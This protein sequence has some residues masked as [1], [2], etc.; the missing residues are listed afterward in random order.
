MQ[1]NNRRI[2]FPFH[3]RCTLICKQQ[4]TKPSIFCL[5]IKGLTQLHIPDVTQ[6]DPWKLTRLMK[7]FLTHT[8]C[9][10]IRDLAEPTD[11]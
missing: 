9:S 1:Q 7:T 2:H 4:I 3:L 5:L 8:K 10:R 6:R 11:S